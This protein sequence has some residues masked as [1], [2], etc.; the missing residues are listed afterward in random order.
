MASRSRS[1]ASA[2]AKPPGRM[3]G[4]QVQV[5]SYYPPEL[6][7][8]LREL[9]KITRRPLADCLR[10]AAEDLLTKHAATIRKAKR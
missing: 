3:L 4:R 9:S 1:K 2:D 8:Q 10:E 7:A 6:A 5:S